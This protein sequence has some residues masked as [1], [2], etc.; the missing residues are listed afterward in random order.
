MVGEKGGCRLLIAHWHCQFTKTCQGSC[1]L[2]WLSNGSFISRQSS[3]FPS[4]ENWLW[5]FE[6]SDYWTEQSEKNCLETSCMDLKDR[7]LW[8]MPENYDKTLRLHTRIF[9]ICLFLIIVLALPF[10]LSNSEYT[11]DSARNLINSRKLS[12]THIH[13]AK[14]SLNVK[15][16]TEGKL[17]ASRMLWFLRGFHWCPFSGSSPF[18]AYSVQKES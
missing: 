12:S 6:L 10:V 16:Q 8:T 3:E 14:A 7:W 11:R 13:R 2:S 17:D 5:L 9:S 18:K 15:L 1:S 4:E